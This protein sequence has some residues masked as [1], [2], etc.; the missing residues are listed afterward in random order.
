[1]IEFSLLDVNGKVAASKALQFV[2]RR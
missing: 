2:V 1:L